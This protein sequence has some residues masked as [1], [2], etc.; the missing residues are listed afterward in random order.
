MFH[1]TRLSFV[2]FLS[3]LTPLAVL[4]ASAS[5]VHAAPSDDWA[6]GGRLSFGALGGLAGLGGLGG[7]GVLGGLASEG[8]P[9]LV[10]EH[11]LAERWWLTLGLSGSIQSRDDDGYARALGAQVGVR[12]VLD[13]DAKVRLVPTARVVTSLG[14][15]KTIG[16]DSEGATVSTEQGDTMLGLDLGLDVE[17][18]V[19]DG[20]ALRLE[21]T[22]ARFAF[23]STTV[24]SDAF[25]DS[26]TSTLSAAL[27]LTPSIAA[28]WSF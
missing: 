12:W 15:R 18:A 13:P 11:R 19:T 14:S 22:L 9:G 28:V 6:I 24:D 7:A 10:F 23:V 5:P 1:C 27:G 4:G 17:L 21:T 2:S 8:G 25:G 20:F 3:F 16:T 26:E